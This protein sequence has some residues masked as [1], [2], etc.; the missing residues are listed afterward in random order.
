MH[1][2]ERRRREQ[3]TPAELALLKTC[4]GEI[5]RSDHRALALA[6]SSAPSERFAART[7][8]PRAISVAKVL[9]VFEAVLRRTSDMIKAD[10]AH[11]RR[12][13]GHQ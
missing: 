13:P 9:V 4:G 5:R 11:F 3:L 2:V 8:T 1:P 10:L 6:R 12:R 7:S